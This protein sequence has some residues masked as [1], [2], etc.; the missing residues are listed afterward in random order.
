MACWATA[1]HTLAS[2]DESCAPEPPS[3]DDAAKAVRQEFLHAWTGY[4]RAAWGHDE[5]APLTNRSNDRWG[6][7]AITMLDSLDSLLLMGHKPEYNEAIGWLLREMP[8]MLNRDVDVPF[9]EVTLFD[10]TLFDALAGKA[11]RRW[12]LGRSNCI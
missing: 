5:L 3:W 11:H 8:S 12:L 1:C 7:L 9:F 10:A 2:A 6:G 4:A